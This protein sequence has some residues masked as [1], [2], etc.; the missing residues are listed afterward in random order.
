MFIRLRSLLALFLFF[1]VTLIQAQSIIGYERSVMQTIE[2]SDEPSLTSRHLSIKPYIAINTNECRMIDSLLTPGCRQSGEGRSWIIRKLYFE[3][4]LNADTG[5][6]HIAADPLLDLQM[7]ADLQG[8]DLLY[9]NSRGLQISGHIGS[10]VAFYTSYLESQGRFASYITDFIR[11]Y[12][13]VPGMNRVK[14]YKGNSF[15]Y[16]VASANIS[17]S[18]WKFLNFQLGYG[19]NGFGNGYRS[20][21]LSD[22]AFQYPFLKISTKIGR[23]EYINLITSFQ[24]LDSDSILDAPQIWYQGYQKKGGSF[25]YLSVHITRWLDFALFEG[26]VWKSRDH[27]DKGFNINQWIPIIYVNTIRYSL[28]DKNNVVLGADLKVR[29]WKKLHLYGQFVLDDLNLDSKDTLSY[30]KTKLGYQA[31]LK[32]FNVAGVRNLNL[33]AEYNEVWPYTYGHTN[34]L[35]SYTHYN[36]ALAH[37]LGANFREAL[38]FVDYRYR[39]LFASLQCLYAIS[40]ADEASAHWGSDPFVSD[41]RAPQ[42]TIV[43]GDVVLQGVRLQRNLYSIRVGYLLNPSYQLCIEGEC[44]YRSAT[45]SGTAQKNLFFSLGI[46]TKLFNQYLDF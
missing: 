27:K 39:R 25:N 19:K 46:K 16:G 42:S 10:K 13:V 3:H 26:I 18:P 43:D 14:D 30:R 12:E 9:R 28:R 24:N 20:L 5:N 7:G 6:F 21:M 22:N 15:D 41:F 40:G 17:Y 34:A 4:F 29:P 8:S 37:P 1:L 36:Q 33:Q 32:W 23:F 31:G 2:Q 38:F 44:T 11:K 35:Q 45:F